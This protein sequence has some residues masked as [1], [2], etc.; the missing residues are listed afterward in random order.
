MRGVL[1]FWLIQP[2]Y[3]R[4]IIMCP[5]LIYR[6]G[7]FLSA[8][9]INRSF[10][11][12]SQYYGRLS[13]FLLRVRTTMNSLINTIPVFI[14][15]FICKY[16]LVVSTPYPNIINIFTYTF[17]ICENIYYCTEDQYHPTS[18]YSKDWG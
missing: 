5:Q 18:V 9:M 11:G 4:I 8:L 13:I 14:N 3:V 17:Y 10:I 15:T 7:P 1:H 12:L 16:I 6:C 2:I